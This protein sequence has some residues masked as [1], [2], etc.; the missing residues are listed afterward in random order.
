MRRDNRIITA[1]DKNGD[2]RSIE[3][4]WSHTADDVPTASEL[5]TVTPTGVWSRVNDVGGGV[6]EVVENGELLTEKPPA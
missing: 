4:I 2:E 6:Y 3:E 1:Y 5:F